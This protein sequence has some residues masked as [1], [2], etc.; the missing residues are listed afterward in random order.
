MLVQIPINKSKTTEFI[1]L[2]SATSITD[3]KKVL[4]PRRSFVD[5]VINLPGMIIENLFKSR[6]SL[7]LQCKCDFVDP[8]QSCKNALKWM[9]IKYNEKDFEYLRFQY[10]HLLSWEVTE[11][12]KEHIKQ[13]QKDVQRTFPDDPFFQKNS[14]GFA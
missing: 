14:I 1:E 4:R 5:T 7:R 8:Y 3:R 11:A 6:N 12:G 13:I 10:E 9:S 2:Q